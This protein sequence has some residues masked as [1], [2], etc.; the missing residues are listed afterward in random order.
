MKTDQCFVKGAHSSYAQC[1]PS[2]QGAM[3]IRLF[4]PKN[5]VQSLLRAKSAYQRPDQPTRD[6]ISH[7]EPMDLTGRFSPPGAAMN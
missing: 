3:E 5:K 2:G 4:I 1:L 6:C 7:T